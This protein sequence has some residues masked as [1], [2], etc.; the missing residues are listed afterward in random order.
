MSR[1]R[2]QVRLGTDTA[3]VDVS[4]SLIDGIDLTDNDQVT[5]ALALH[6]PE[7]VGLV[8][9][10]LRA[11]GVDL[12]RHTVEIV[13]ARYTQDDSPASQSLVPGTP[14]DREHE[15]EGWTTTDVQVHESTTYTVPVMHPVG[16]GAAEIAAV[17]YDDYC[18]ALHPDALFAHTVGPDEVTVAGAPQ[19][20]DPVWPRWA[21]QR[22]D[23]Q[24]DPERSAAAAEAT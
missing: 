21:A 4:T 17:G 1:I 20:D 2:T 9:A 11:R 12:E 13:D 6:H 18:Q 23:H 15:S 3:E 16:A 24:P 10:E 22:P 7:L 5:A 8:R 14:N 19:D